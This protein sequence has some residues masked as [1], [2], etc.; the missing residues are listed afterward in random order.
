MEKLAG[1]ERNE[2]SLLLAEAFQEQGKFQESVEAL[3]SFATSDIPDVEMRRSVLQMGAAWNT[4]G[5]RL[6]DLRERIDNLMSIACSEQPSTARATALRLAT[7]MVTQESDKDIKDAARASNLATAKARLYYIDGDR[8]S[9]RSTLSEAL[10]AL[11]EHKIKSSLVLHLYTARAAVSC[12]EGS[13]ADALG[14]LLKA[15]DW[16]NHLGR[17]A[18]GIATN[19]ALCQGRLGRYADQAEWAERVLEMPTANSRIDARLK[20]TYY[21]AFS[22]A[23]RYKDD[24]VLAAL[25]RGDGIA[26]EGGA[27]KQWWL[28]RKADVLTLCRRPAEARLCAVESMA[29]AMEPTS[30]AHAG[31][32]ARWL[33]YALTG[34]RETAIEPSTIREAIVSLGSL[35]LDKIDSTEVRGAIGTIQNEWDQLSFRKDIEASLSVLPPATITQLWRLWEPLGSQLPAVSRFLDILEARIRAAEGV[36]EAS[37]FASC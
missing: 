23:M 11:E 2:G 4:L 37:A 34:P 19:I 14:D 22:Q 20:A 31:S 33:V 8:A 25:R 9:A 26:T 28:L 27:D 29:L 15:H 10:D 3:G 32:L 16:T 7:G 17:P 30:V 12:A 5:P 6:Q 13:Y 24:A 1:A 21:L 36:S 18:C 35:R